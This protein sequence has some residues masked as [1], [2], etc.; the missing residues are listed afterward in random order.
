MT[1]VK[2]IPK[3]INNN[4]FATRKEF[5]TASAIAKNRPVGS[6]TGKN[7]FQVDPYLAIDGNAVYPVWQP[8]G[9]F[10]H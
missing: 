9:A 4:E 8:G 7:K 10:L 6:L 3:N 5:L 2:S 1:A